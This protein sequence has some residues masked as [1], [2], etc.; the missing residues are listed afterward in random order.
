[1]RSGLEIQSCLLHQIAMENDKL[2]SNFPDERLAAS[3]EI[4]GKSII[5]E[6][7]KIK[8]Y[9]W[10][11]SGNAWVVFLGSSPGGSPP[12]GKEDKSNYKSEILFSSSTNHFAQTNDGRGFWKK[13]VEYS[14]TLFPKVPDNDL[15]R[16][17]LAGNLMEIQEGDSTKLNNEEL[18]KGATESFKV[19]S[20][21]RPKLI[22]CLQKNVYELIYE[23]AK[24]IDNELIKCEGV[25]QINSGTKRNVKYK[26][27]VNY[28]KSKDKYW[29]KWILTRTPMHPSRSNFC[30]D[31]NFKEQFLEELKFFANEY[32]N[33]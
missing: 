19:I 10:F 21:V 12:K 5:E 32:L 23:L 25:L 22:I 26:V 24:G 17:M 7:K 28:F 18:K 15:Y 9:Y 29:G 33:L 20:I 2:Y 11:G 13:I 14:K 30:V 16:L 1:M 27:P 8:Q 31:K 3:L 6:I 4:D